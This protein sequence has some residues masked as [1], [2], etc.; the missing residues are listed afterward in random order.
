VL[1]GLIDDNRYTW[2]NKFSNSIGYYNIKKNRLTTTSITNFYISTDFN[3]FSKKELYRYKLAYKL[4]FAFL[5]KRNSINRWVLFRLGSRGWKK[6]P[7]HRRGWLQKSKSV[8]SFFGRKKTPFLKVNSKRA[9]NQPK[10]FNIKSRFIRVFYENRNILRQIYNKKR[11]TQRRFNRFFSSFSKKDYVTMLNH[12]EFSIK[13]ILIRSKFF[14]LES[15]IN[16]AI[17]MG[18]IFLNGHGV[19][20]IT[21]MLKVGDVL[22][23]IISKFFFLNYRTIF[24][25]ITKFKKYLYYKIWIM[26]RNLNNI[27]KQKPTYVTSKVSVLI[28]YYFDVPRFLEVEYSTLS[29]VVINKP[30]F[31]KDYMYINRFFVNGYLMRLYTWKYIS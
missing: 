19:N 21:K 2:L 20:K 8:L 14:F 9:R 15:Q 29:I 24:S 12:L 22:Q 4:N 13:N 17:H 30:L 18:L 26:T 31:F 1:V 5:K 11:F 23:I 6:L 3:F 10:D 27:F 25:E 16:E 7:W 28:N